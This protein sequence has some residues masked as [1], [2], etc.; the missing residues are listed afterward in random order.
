MLA[1]EAVCLG[2]WRKRPPR[3]VE[4]AVIFVSLETCHCRPASSFLAGR[5]VFL[6]CRTTDPISSAIISIVSFSFIMYSS[7]FILSIRTLPRLTRCCRFFEGFLFFFNLLLYVLHR[8]LRDD[9]GNNRFATSRFHVCCLVVLAVD[10]IVVLAL[11][12][13]SCPSSVFTVSS[14]SCACNVGC[15]WG[16]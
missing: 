2:R 14:R 15:C 11:P 3:V 4:T 12:R 16:R 6:V 7:I 5:D 8:V 10:E 13:A 9:H 1:R